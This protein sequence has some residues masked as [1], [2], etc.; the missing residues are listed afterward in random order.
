M[1]VTVIWT[2]DTEASI[3]WL[4]PDFSSSQN[5]VTGYH[6]SVRETSEKYDTVTH[7]KENFAVEKV[8]IIN[9]K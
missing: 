5:E 8:G 1:N 2:N 6:L 3:F 7:Y 4:P 9:S